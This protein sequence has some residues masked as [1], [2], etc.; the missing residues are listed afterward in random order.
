[1]TFLRQHSSLAPKTH[2]GSPTTPGG[3]PTTGSGSPCRRPTWKI[4]YSVWVIT[5]T[6]GMV[7]HASSEMAGDDRGLVEVL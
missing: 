4:L 3:S 1:M 7:L 6:L 2:S 5:L